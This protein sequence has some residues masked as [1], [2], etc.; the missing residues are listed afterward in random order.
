[1]CWLLQEV[2][3]EGGVKARLVDGEVVEVTA[4]ACLYNLSIRP[5]QV[6]MAED[7]DHGDDTDDDG[8]PRKLLLSL[9]KKKKA[10]S[11]VGL[12]Q[13]ASSL[14]VAESEPK[15]FELPALRG[16][17]SRTAFVAAMHEA[18]SAAGKGKTDGIAAGDAAKHVRDGVKVSYAGDWDAMV[19]V[20]G[21]KQRLCEAIIDEEE[22]FGIRACLP[23]PEAWTALIGKVEDK[24]GRTMLA[25]VD[26][27]AHK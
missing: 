11:A 15:R 3:L 27:A 5:R 9:L 26:C 6:E 2:K 21:A 8:D 10:T 17:A 16:D 20:G 7:D 25:C 18:L 24:R 12:V 23:D 14:A 1:M 13:S 4:P 19:S 22:H